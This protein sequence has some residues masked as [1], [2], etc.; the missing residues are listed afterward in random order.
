[1]QELPELNHD[2]LLGM[3]EQNVPDEVREFI[4]KYIATVAQCEALLLIAARPDESW[5]LRRIAVRLYESDKQTAHSLNEL[6]SRG[7]LTCS[8][9]Y[10]SLTKS[11]EIVDMLGKLREAYA[12]YLIQVTNVIHNKP[13]GIDGA[14]ARAPS[15]GT[16]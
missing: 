14:T 7:L 10:Y 1:M 3:P 4:I 6:C 15:D 13:P 11:V 9:G 16:L 2:E 8:D 12:R 5:K